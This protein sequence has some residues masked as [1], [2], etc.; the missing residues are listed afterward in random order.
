LQPVAD[1]TVSIQATETLLMAESTP[2]LTASQWAVMHA[3]ELGTLDVATLAEDLEA[4]AKYGLLEYVDGIWRPT[5]E[6]RMLVAL[7]RQ[8]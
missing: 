3:V 5:Q 2:T 4:L 1:A 6:G 7:R 8:I